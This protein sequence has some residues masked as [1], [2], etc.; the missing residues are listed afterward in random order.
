M[1]PFGRNAEE[2]T[3]TRC[4]FI[5]SV[6][7]QTDFSANFYISTKLQSQEIIQLNLF[8]YLFDKYI[9]FFAMGLRPNKM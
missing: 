4:N 9:Q 7:L 3:N 2:A 5:H 8:L 6:S 1:A